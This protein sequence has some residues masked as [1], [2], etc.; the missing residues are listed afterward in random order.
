[1]PTAKNGA[2][3]GKKYQALIES[4]TEIS[5][6]EANTSS[7]SLRTDGYLEIKNGKQRAMMR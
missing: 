3:V 7:E 5:P 1:M 2:H 6:M 4:G